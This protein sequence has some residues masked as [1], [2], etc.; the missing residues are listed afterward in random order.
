M[1][2]IHNIRKAMNLGAFDFLIKPI[3]LQDLEK[4]REKSDARSS[5]DP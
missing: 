2:D 1:G 5:P 4:T 3:D